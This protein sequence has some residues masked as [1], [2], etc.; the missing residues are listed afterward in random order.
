[1]YYFW[2]CDYFVL[3]RVPSLYLFIVLWALTFGFPLLYFDLFKR[4]AVLY[5]ILLIF[6]E[7]RMYLLYFVLTYTYN[8]LPFMISMS[9]YTLIF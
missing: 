1:M 5:V 2:V 9:I 6:G 7:F 8:L 3:F 4:F